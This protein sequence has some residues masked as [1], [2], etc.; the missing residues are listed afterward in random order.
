MEQIASETWRD[1]IE[2]AVEA[3]QAD[4]TRQS[5]ALVDQPSA[6]PSGEQPQQ[7]P[8][9]RPSPVPQLPVLEVRPSE[10]IGAL[11][12]SVVSQQSDGGLA[13][14]DSSALPSRRSSVS[15]VET[16]T[17]VPG[18]PIGS[19]RPPLS[20]QP[21]LEAII[22]QARDLDESASGG[23]KRPAEVDADVLREAGAPSQLGPQLVDESPVIPVSSEEEDPP[24]R[25][26]LVLDKEDVVWLSGCKPR[27]RFILCR[28]FRHWQLWIV[29]IRRVVW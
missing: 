23:L 16:N 2:E 11:Q 18:T 25:D 4:L 3:A 13:S 7:Q 9:E 8:E 10:L 19:E 27:R 22:E 24:L 15:P 28:S 21:R 29:W 1:A 26:A 6:N 20:H 14:L 17:R 5:A 12:P